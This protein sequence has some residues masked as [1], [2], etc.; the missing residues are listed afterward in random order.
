MFFHV[1]LGQFSEICRTLLRNLKNANFGEVSYQNPDFRL[2]CVILQKRPVFSQQSLTR[3]FKALRSFKNHA[4]KIYVKIREI[5]LCLSCVSFPYPCL[6]RDT[7]PKFTNFQI[8]E[9]CP[10]NF[11]ELSY[12]FRRSVLLSCNGKAAGSYLKRSVQISTKVKGLDQAF[13]PKGLRVS[14]GQSP[15]SLSA[16]VNYVYLRNPF[17]SG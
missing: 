4:M 3:I 9:K 13:F 11:G 10:A 8:S 17:A 5:M 7:F 16:V 6:C 15:W 2:Q 1:G 12:K 14:K